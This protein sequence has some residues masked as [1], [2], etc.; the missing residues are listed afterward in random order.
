MNAFVVAIFTSLITGWGLLWILWKRDPEA[1]ARAVS[2]IRN[3]DIGMSY[4]ILGQIY[5]RLTIV[6]AVVLAVCLV[7]TTW[8]IFRQGSWKKQTRER[9][10][11]SARSKASSH[12]IL[13]NNPAIISDSTKV[14]FVLLTLRHGSFG[15]IVQEISVAGNHPDVDQCCR[16]K[17]GDILKF[18]VNETGLLNSK[19][20][21]RPSDLLRIQA[22]TTSK[23]AC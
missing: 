16:L 5:P 18:E 9:H 23:R 10:L 22:V 4:M 3:I 13:E 21:S 11:A 2:S 12:W 1:P 8:I 7:M 19:F 17:E 14:I 6:V 15:G 20:V